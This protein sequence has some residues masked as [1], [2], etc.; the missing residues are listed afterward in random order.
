MLH[1]T[2]EGRT[3]CTGADKKNSNTSRSVD[4]VSHWR[5]LMFRLRYL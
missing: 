1:E 3:D 4:G 5:I 2:R